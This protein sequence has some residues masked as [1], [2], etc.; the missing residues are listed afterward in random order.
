MQPGNHNEER[1][2]QDPE[3]FQAPENS[4]PASLI[5]ESGPGRQYR[6]RQKVKT[7]AFQVKAHGSI[8][9]T[10]PTG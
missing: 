1:G 2:F 10:N 9:L 8:D 5:A 7:L 4:L 6:L 3:C